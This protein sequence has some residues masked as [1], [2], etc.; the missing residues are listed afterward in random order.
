MKY[1]YIFL[2]LFLFTS[3][4]YFINITNIET[5]DNITDNITVVSGYWN[6]K[7]KHNKRI[8][9][10]KTKSSIKDTYANITV[11]NKINVYF[12]TFAGAITENLVSIKYLKECAKKHNLKLIDYK[13]FLEEPGNLLSMY[14]STNDSWL[15]NAKND[16]KAIRSSKALNTWAKFQCYF[17]FQKV[18]KVD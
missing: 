14:E 2:F 4:L 10:R 1:S 12:E 16:V 9:L 5:Y 15:K 3:I 17:M 7:N 11:G 6:V 18:R 8:T 13:S